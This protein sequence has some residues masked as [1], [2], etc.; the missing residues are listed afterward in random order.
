MKTKERQVDGAGGAIH[1]CMKTPTGSGQ[2]PGG[3]NR[4]ASNCVG[5]EGEGRWEQR[6]K[7]LAFAVLLRFK[8]AKYRMRYYL[9]SEK[10]KAVD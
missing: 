8:Q 2:A 1:K 6:T 3:Q 5:R 10:L 4:R 9:S 7:D